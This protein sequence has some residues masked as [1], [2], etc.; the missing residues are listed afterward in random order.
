M[1]M[2][3]VATEIVDVA[4]LIERDLRIARARRQRAQ[5]HRGTAALAPDQFGDRVDLVRGE[6][7]D[8]GPARQPR[9]LPVAGKV[10][11]RQPRALR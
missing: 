4:G 3:S 5:H 11:L 8:G 7:D 2:A 6:G 10:R 1:P 9:H